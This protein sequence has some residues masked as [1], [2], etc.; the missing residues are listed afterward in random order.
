MSTLVA[1]RITSPP[2]FLYHRPRSRVSTAFAQPILIHHFPV[3]VLN[4]PPNT[5]AECFDVD[6]PADHN[7]PIP[8]VSSRPASGDCGRTLDV[9]CPVDSETP[10]PVFRSKTYL[11]RLRPSGRPCCTAWTRRCRTWAS[12]RSTRRTPS[13]SSTRCSWPPPRSGERLSFL[14]S[15]DESY[16]F[17]ELAVIFSFNRFKGRSLHRRQSVAHTA[18]T[19]VRRAGAAEVRR[20]AAPFPYLE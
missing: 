5:A 12:R 15:D 7:T 4:Q 16:L 6:C 13:S 10:L 1:Q 19:D 8:G 20:Q 2:P 9:N 3:S 11:R 14:D 18:S 17:L